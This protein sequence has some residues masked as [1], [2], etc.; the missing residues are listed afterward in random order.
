MVKGKPWTFEEQKQL[1]KLREEGYKVAEIAAKMGKTPEAIMKKLQRLGLKVVQ[2]QENNRTTTTEFI[3]PKQLYTV[4]QSLEILAGAIKALQTSGLNKT[5]VIRLK[6]L[7]HAAS[8]Y[9]TR[10]AEYLDYRRI[11]QELFELTR[12]FEK[13][14]KEQ[15]TEN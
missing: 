12:R 6:S 3:V 15:A 13:A 7:I 14:I 4:E 1:R 10:Y 2:Q 9:Q 8:L 5:E 11:E